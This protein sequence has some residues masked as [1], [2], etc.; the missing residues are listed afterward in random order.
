M[1]I[2]QRARRDED[3]RARRRAI[4]DTAAKMLRRRAYADLTMAEVARHCELAKGTLY[5]YFHSK[6]ALFLAA[7]EQQLGEWFDT[8]APQLSA[9]DPSCD[10]RRRIAQTI[11]ST[12][13]ARP[14]LS[15][16]LAIVHNVLEQNIEAE[17]ALAFK[18]MLLERLRFGG[19]ILEKALPALPAGAGLPLLLRIYAVV[20]GLRQLADPAPVVAAVLERPEMAPLRV[21]FQ[22]ELAETIHAL[23]TGAQVQRA[24]ADA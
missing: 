16:L 8:L 3:K 10:Q 24:T 13:A 2:K 20:V 18:Q 23:V 5:L 15:D 4:L 14:T 21:D 6:E 17:T 12:V 7:L 1:P 9:L 22:R 19:D 11:A